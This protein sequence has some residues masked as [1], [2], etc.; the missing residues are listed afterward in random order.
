M[1]T[2]TTTMEAAP[3]TGQQLVAAVIGFYLVALAASG[4]FGLVQ[5]LTG[6][7]PQVFQLTQVGPT[8]A[9]LV[10]LAC[11]R[12]VRS[13]VGPALVPRGPGAWRAALAGAS[14]LVVW[15]GCRW[16]AGRR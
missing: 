4:G 11:S 10:V 15:V 9:V 1:A 7:D 12:R 8:V 16:S 6:I 2:T 14:M 3:P 5:P 13:L